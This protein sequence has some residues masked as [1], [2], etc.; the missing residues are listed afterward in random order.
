VADDREPVAVDPA[1][2]WVAAGG[3]ERDH[4]VERGNELYRRCSALFVGRACR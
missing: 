3:R 1:G 4:L 2:E